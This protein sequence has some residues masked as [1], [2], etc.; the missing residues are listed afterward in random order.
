MLRKTFGSKREEVRVDSRKLRN[1]ELKNAYLSEKYYSQVTEKE[2]G[3]HVT[4]MESKRNIHRFF[5]M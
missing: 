3:G 5:I 2:M 4:S 1:E